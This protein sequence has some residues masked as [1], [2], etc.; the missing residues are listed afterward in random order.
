MGCWAKAGVLD[1]VFE[2]LMRVRIEVVSLNSTFV[3]V[4]RMARGCQKN[5]LQAIRKSRGS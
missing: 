1:A 2:R 3:K 5:S 4:H